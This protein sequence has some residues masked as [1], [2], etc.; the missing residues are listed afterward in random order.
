MEAWPRS[1]CRRRG[2]HA[3]V[4]STSPLLQTASG[5]GGS[6]GKEARAWAQGL[7]NKSLVKR[8]CV[9]GGWISE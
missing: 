6:E 9:N 3:P 5:Q 2:A 1:P 4:L 7:L 8:K